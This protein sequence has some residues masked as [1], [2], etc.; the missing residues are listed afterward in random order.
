MVKTLVW[1]L[2][3]ST[4]QVQNNFKVCAGVLVH[5]MCIFSVHFTKMKGLRTV[6]TRRSESSIGLAGRP[7]TDLSFW[8][9]CGYAWKIKYLQHWQV[10]N[11]S[12]AGWRPR[13]VGGRGVSAAWLARATRQDGTLGPRCMPSVTRYGDVHAVC[14][15]TQSCTNA[16][17]PP[18]RIGHPLIRKK[19]NGPPPLLR[20]RT[21]SVA[22]QTV[23]FCTAFVK[24]WTECLV[25]MWIARFHE[26][27]FVYFQL[28]SL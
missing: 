23:L 13:R 12:V 5:G 26:S 20:V 18:F 25:W 6:R 19:K 28:L 3:P 2:W 10:G 17:F 14:T 21:S 16:S 15:S 7:G 24:R 8:Y 11:P 9:S 27:S 1:P 4:N 22:S